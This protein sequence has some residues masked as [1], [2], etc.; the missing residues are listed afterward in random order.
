MADA[1]GTVFLII[2]AKLHRDFSAKL[3]SR[4]KIK[5]MLK[6]SLPMMPTTVIWWITNVSDRYIVTYLKGSGENG[7]YSAA[8]KIPTLITLVATVFIEAWQF[9][10]ISDSKD[11]EDRNSFF[12]EVFERYQA[13]IFFGCAC[14][15]PLSQIATRAL[16]DASYYEAWTFIPVLLVAT[17]FSSLTSFMGTIYTVSKRTVMSMVS[18]LFGAVL[19]IILNILL[20]PDMG[21]QGAGIATMISYMAVFL[22]RAVSSKR[23]MPFKL[24]VPK[25]VLNT[26]IIIAQAVLML[27]GFEYNLWAQIVLVLALALL[28]ARS[29]ITAV[30]GILKNFKKISKKT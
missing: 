12:G 4:E 6:F 27:I 10:A 26:A 2:A 14:L 22:I 18:A 29:V 8:Y 24:G 19:N 21:A 30:W 15:I 23:Y 13:I 28:N 25:L 1:V 11:G 20:I 5:E 3:V 7:L 17:V 16:L 9:S